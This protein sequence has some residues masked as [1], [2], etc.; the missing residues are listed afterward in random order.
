ML[1]EHDILLNGYRL[2]FCADVYN[3]MM[4]FIYI[5]LDDFSVLLCL[6]VS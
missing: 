5:M 4:Y 3:D 2:F 6:S 1:K